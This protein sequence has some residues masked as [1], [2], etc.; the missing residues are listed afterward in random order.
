MAPL[1]PFFFTDPSFFFL[2]FFGSFLGDSRFS[3]LSGIESPY[4]LDIVASLT[5]YDLATTPSGSPSNLRRQASTP[6]SRLIFSGLPNLTP[7]ATARRYPSVVLMRIGELTRHLLLA[8]KSKPFT[9]WCNTLLN[10]TI[11]NNTTYRRGGGN[12]FFTG[13]MLGSMSHPYYGYGPGYMPPYYAGG[14]D[15]TSSAATA[16]TA[17]T[18]G[19]LTMR[20][21]LLARCSPASS[22]YG[23]CG[24]LHQRG[25]SNRT[26]AHRHGRQLYLG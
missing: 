23:V 19:P 14:M 11:I 26:V 10:A 1:A 18:T 24:D 12:G 2:D 20:I 3:F 16:L 7:L 8:E 4:N 22:P 5:L 21:R 15:T 6:A 9:P 25:N 17:T 13:W